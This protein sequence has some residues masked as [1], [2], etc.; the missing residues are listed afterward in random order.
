MSIK[1]TTREYEQAKLKVLCITPRMPTSDKPGSMAPALRQIES[2]RKLGIEVIV[3]D[4]KG[5][6]VVKYGPAVP[7]MWTKLNQVDLIHAHFGY[8]GWIARMQWKRPVVL[9]FMGDD[10][11]GTPTSSGSLTLLSRFM[12]QCNRSLARRVDQVI[13]KSREMA[14]VISPT[15][16]H[17][18]PNGVDLELFR[19]MAKDEAKSRLGLDSQKLYL[20]FPGDPSNPRKGYQLAKAATEETQ[21]LTGLPIEILTLWGRQ[22]DEV[23]WCMNA[24]EA[25]WMTSLIEGSPNVV[26]EAMGCNL[27][28]VGVPVGDVAELL[29][30]VQGYFVCERDPLQLAKAMA[31]VLQANLQ[32]KGREA[33]IKLGLSLEQVALRIRNVYMRSLTPSDHSTLHNLR[34]SLEALPIEDEGISTTES[35]TAT[36]EAR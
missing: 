13:V 10:L 34:N 35:I 15:S 1:E 7:R 18:I 21:R 3:Q 23:P 11:L 20:L 6:P 5:I 29:D 24:C 17:I 30:G 4:M 26:K 25:M 12:V 8:C 9:S 2:L 19:P 32:V 31:C 27:S 14:Q 16:C 36:V 33:L 22:P 28:V